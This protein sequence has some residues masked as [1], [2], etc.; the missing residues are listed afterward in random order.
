MPSNLHESLLRQ[1]REV[2]SRVKDALADKEL[3]GLPE[4]MQAH[5]EIMFQLNQAGDCENPELLDLLTE[6][7]AEVQM[8]VQKIVTWQTEIHGKIK[9]IANKKKL[10]GAYGV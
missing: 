6:T 2:I 9:T 1:L 4:M 8:V 3:D 5:Q 10:A 7:N